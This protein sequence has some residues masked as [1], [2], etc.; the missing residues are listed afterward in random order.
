MLRLREVLKRLGWSQYERDAYCSLVTEGPSTAADLELRASIPSGRGHS[1]VKKLKARKEGAI[2]KLRGRPAKYDAQHPRMVL[3]GALNDLKEQ[4]E[5]ALA[6]AEPAWDLRAEGNAGVGEKSWIV[7]GLG[8]TVNEI[9]ELATRSATSFTLVLDNL[10][11]VRSK[12]VETLQ[13]IIAKGGI[14]KVVSTRAS[15]GDLE[16]LAAA[17]VIAKA[18]DHVKSGYCVSDHK[19]ILW[20]TGK[21]D[22]A[23]AV[24]DDRLAGL[25]EREFEADYKDTARVEV[26]KV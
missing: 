18:V 26:E 6:E 25:L 24:V 5:A 15:K 23:T 4:C 2:R 12:D 22:T 10:N 7:D 21:S 16:R 11:W 20:V 1:V 9:R 8:G 17:G 14:V 19:T 3:E 13:R